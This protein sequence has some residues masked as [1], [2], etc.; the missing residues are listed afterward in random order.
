M[1]RAA[2]LRAAGAYADEVAWHLGLLTLKA[3]VLAGLRI[4]DGN[5]YA[6]DE[7][8]IPQHPEALLDRLRLAWQEYEGLGRVLG[9][10]LEDRHRIPIRLERMAATH[11]WND[12]LPLALVA[13]ELRLDD[14][15]AAVTLAANFL[16][17]GLLRDAEQALG[18][19]RTNTR[20][21]ASLRARAFRNSAGISERSGDPY[22][23]MEYARRAVSE[24]PDCPL[25]VADYC[26]YGRKYVAI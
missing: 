24:S 21:P 26:A 13:A 20:M 7:R 14:P 11:S 2:V 5:K 15:L 12:A 17:G 10:Y 16:R 4:Q 3:A 22:L 6:P 23:A 25:S 9:A 1:S 8:L 19:V 18:P